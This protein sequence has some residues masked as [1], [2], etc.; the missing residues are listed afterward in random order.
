VKV[1]KEKNEVLIMST[2]L[3][4]KRLLWWRTRIWRYANTKLKKKLHLN[5]SVIDLLIVLIFFS[6]EDTEVVSEEVL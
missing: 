5:F 3:V 2:N 4:F 6:K 1:T